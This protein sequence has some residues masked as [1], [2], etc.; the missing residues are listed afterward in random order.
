MPSP[1]VPATVVQP[2]KVFRGVGGVIT[3]VTSETRVRVVPIT[4]GDGTIDLAVPSFDVDLGATPT[5]GK[6]W[7]SVEVDD[8]GVDAFNRQLG[9]DTNAWDL[10]LG[11]TTLGSGSNDLMRSAFVGAVYI[12]ESRYQQLSIGTTE[13]PWPPKQY[14][15]YQ[16]TSIAYHFAADTQNAGRRYLGFQAEIVQRSGDFVRVVLLQ[17]DGTKSSPHWINTADPDE[18][19]RSPPKEAIGDLDD[20]EVSV[21]V[22]GTT[23]DHGP[24]FIALPFARGIGLDGG[25]VPLGQAE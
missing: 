14:K 15:L 12:E 4:S 20:G 24:I 17:A 19:L 16:L 8:R 6:S 13:W 25:K 1:S 5:R 7:D 10:Q 23:Y 21:A 22:Q 11:I 2:Y 18:C 3:G 9:P